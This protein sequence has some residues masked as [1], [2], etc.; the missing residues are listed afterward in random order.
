MLSS[1]PANSP[2]SRMIGSSPIRSVKKPRK[3]V[4]LAQVLKW[5][6]K[7]PIPTAATCDQPN[8]FQDGNLLYDI[9]VEVLRPDLQNQR[10]ALEQLEADLEEAQSSEDVATEMQSLGTL[11]DYYYSQGMIARAVEMRCHQLKL[12]KGHGT[13]EDLG[14]LCGK[15]GDLYIEMGDSSNAIKYHDTGLEIQ[16]K[17]TEQSLNKIPLKALRERSKNLSKDF[18]KGAQIHLDANPHK[19]TEWRKHHADIAS[20]N[21]AAEMLATIEQLEVPIEIGE[22][23]ERSG[24]RIKDV[25]DMIYTKCAVV[26]EKSWPFRTLEDILAGN[27]ANEEAMFS[28]EEIHKGVRKK[29]AAA[30]KVS[31]PSTHAHCNV[32]Y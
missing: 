12:M 8:A 25:M 28:P 4:R 13:T 22:K 5:V 6:R 7:L 32:R 9:A 23:A 14:M 26:V 27:Q 19:Y 29:K 17:M 21:P 10:G 11:A 15:L 1:S 20:W 24:M 18:R 3:R 31:H 2:V 30:A 16:R